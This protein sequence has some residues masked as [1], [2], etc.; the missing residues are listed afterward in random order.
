[1]AASDKTEPGTPKRRR[2]AR[3]RGE[4]ARSQEL[5]ASINMAAGLTALT[6]GGTFAYQQVRG[7]MLQ[8]FGQVGGEALE[9]AAFLA[10]LQAAGVKTLWILAPVLA[11]L[12]A[13]TLLVNYLQVGF[14]ISTQA[15]SLKWGRMNPASG[16]KRLFGMHG[17][18]ELA[19]AAFK[20]ALTG[21][22]VWSDLK[23]RLPDLILLSGAPLPAGLAATGGLLWA[24][25][26]KIGLLFL[27]LG[28]ADYAWQRF[29]F[30]RKLRM[31]KQ[32]IRDEMRESEGDP[33]VKGKQRARHRKMAQT[34]M[35]AEVAK[36]DVV[37]INPTHYAVALRY[38]S[39]RMRAPR[40]VAK[41]QRLWA[42]LIVKIARRH[43]VPV[44]QN[45]PV[46]RLLYK[47]VEVGQEIPPTLYRAVAEILAALYRIRGRHKGGRA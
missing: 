7:F 15:L 28:A 25:A 26:W 17:W 24:V 6:L 40:V 8:T 32:E 23:H 4:V 16:V 44:I 14:R 34:R 19:K 12:L 37:T 20:I 2:E 10:R 27:V 45:K 9:S 35:A 29:D 5:S 13:A 21:Q 33:Q 22:I 31:S 36:A 18:I 46:T 38:D 42:K 47:R 11:A 30:E 39:R 1:M 41:G 43:Q 3:D